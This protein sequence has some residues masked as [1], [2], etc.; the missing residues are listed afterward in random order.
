M[1][2]IVDETLRLEGTIAE[3]IF[4][5]GENGY[6]VC[7]FETEEEQLTAVGA[8]PSC[9][10][11]RSYILEGAF[12]VHSKYGEQFA[13]THAEEVMPTTKE[14]ITDF[15]ASG[16]IKGVGPKMAAAIVA[17][18]GDDALRII[19][20]EP[21]KLARVSGIGPKKIEAITESFATHKAFADISVYFRKHGIPSE[22]AL[23]LYR[24]YGDDT[25]ET[26]E[27]NPYRLVDEIYSISFKKADTI[28]FA[29]G[30][31]ADSK[32]RLGS[33]AKYVIS[34]YIG[35][36][37][38]YI[39]KKELCEQV[40][41]I[42]ETSS[43]RVEDIL[44]D[45]AIEG[46]IKIDILEEQEVVYRL[47]YY[48]AEQ[49]ITA[50]LMDLLD[51]EIKPVRDAEAIIK[52]S[53]E[54]A[55]LTFSEEQKKAIISALNNGVSIITGGP[56]T[57]KTTIIK[58]ILNILEYNDLSYGIAA[59]TGRAAKRITQT[60]GRPASTLHR[61]L[62][63]SYT[64][65]DEEV[66]RFGRNAENPLE[67][68]VIIVDEASMVDL[69]LMNALILAMNPGMR[70]IMVGDADQLPSVGAGNVL[71][72]MIESEYIHSVKLKEIFRQAA[73]SMIVVNAHKINRGEYPDVNQSDGDFFMMMRH[74]EREMVDVILELC[75][76]RLP[77]AYDF[78]PIKDI[79]VLTPVRKGSI[80]SIDLNRELQKKLNPAGN[81]GEKEFAGK[82]FREGDKVMQIKNNYD[83]EWKKAGEFSEG[84]GIFNGDVGFIEKIDK[85][86]DEITVLFDEDKYVT[87]DVANLDELEPAYAIT[88]HKSQGCEFPVVIM[89]MSWFPSM[90]AT[91]NLLYTAVTRGEKMVILV[92]SPDK[93]KAMV[94]NVQ[95]TMRY[96]GLKGRLKRIIHEHY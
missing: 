59:P 80:G 16:I 56:G 51:A 76:T 52:R 69:L 87:Y 86:F 40:A 46:D 94:D 66:L 39:P 63:Y 93:M 19:E 96:S 8:L 26:I 88:V 89:P 54:D 27:E 33:A 42:T 78:D 44:I 62:E 83:M 84:K 70:L 30:F 48:V 6:T 7:I 38:T 95:M 13:F 2:K 25:I 15:L 29:L 68:D 55:G 47:P 75:S 41:E 73:E 36:G 37:N 49:N 82:L 1:V 85:D 67:Q 72:D 34:N 53:E 28:A 61:L 12:K 14:G 90:L 10:K 3:V 91:R 60:T 65:D 64:E 31:E 18:L 23:K 79:Q 43:E 5:N 71:S 21:Q 77:N 24:L 9:D 58:G 32:F 20:E 92:G 11:G 35:S 81:A 74:S 50:G 17:E 45:M 4:H 57:G 22:Y